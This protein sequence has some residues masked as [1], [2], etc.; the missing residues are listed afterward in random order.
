MATT[1]HAHSSIHVN[2]SQ[3]VEG[4]KATAD[5]IIERV[6][7]VSD[8]SR[9]GRVRVDFFCYQANGDRCADMNLA[10]FSTVSAVEIDKDIAAPI[11]FKQT[12]PQPKPISFLIRKQRTCFEE[13][14][15]DV[16][17][18]ESCACEGK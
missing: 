4:V 5:E 7:R 11:S 12:L 3:T 6:T 14:T 1:S 8:R 17:A 10:H 18:K 2:F 15:S 16:F 9:L 13:G